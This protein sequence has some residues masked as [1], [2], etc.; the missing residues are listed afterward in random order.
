MSKEARWII[1]NYIK[2]TKIKA[3]QIILKTSLV[4]VNTYLKNL[5]KNSKVLDFCCGEGITSNY[6]GLIREDVNIDAIDQNKELIDEAKKLNTKNVNFFNL[7]VFK[8][9]FFKNNFFSS[10]DLIICND[11]IHHF[12]YKDH[13]F[14]IKKL[15]NKLNKNGEILIKEVDK[16]DFFDYKLTNFFDKKLYK[17]DFL[18]F[19]NLDE[20]KKLLNRIGYKDEEIIVTKQKHIWPASRT[21]FKLKKI[22]TKKSLVSEKEIQENN[23]L[24]KKKGL[25]NIIITGESG[26]IGKNLVKS[27][28]G[29]TKYNLT[30][31]SRSVKSPIK[32]ISTFYSE[33][34]ELR[35]NSIIFDNVDFVVHLA[36][37]VKYNNGDNIY[38]NNING[39]K[40]LLRSIGKRNKKNIKKIIFASSI[41]AIDRDK[42][43]QCNKPLSIFSKPNPS[44]YYG[45]SKLVGEKLIKRFTSK[46][47]ILRICW[48]YGKY[49]TPD[50]H[51]KFLFNATKKNKIYSFFN[52][53]A[54]ISLIHI[55]D[56]L[57]IIKYFL[58]EN[59]INRTY[60][61]HNG[62][63]ISL[64]QIFKFYKDFHGKRIHLNIPTFIINFSKKI[65]MF[66]PFKIKTLLMDT[67]L[68][69]NLLFEENPNIKINK[70]FPDD[71]QSLATD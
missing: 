69:D 65:C 8:E 51:M 12:K 26:F 39:T 52:F 46:N 29:K 24:S 25:Q 5:S 21:I 67:M 22:N 60:F 1:T 36:S 13:K 15:I 32:N 56:L 54:R 19:R 57:E 45:Y 70:K 50:T 23:L 18:S 71:I 49:M 66:L 55:D 53:P 59:K 9:N 48:C 62:Q 34:S 31:I 2:K 14:I 63:S 4:P 47:I 41:G 64:G 40:Y 44:S 11:I 42:K 6:I 61:V 17:D 43:D 28:V 16:K 20:W 33:L 38:E 7:E 35:E 37:E 3:L 30:V 10:Y 58:E 27:L 68:A